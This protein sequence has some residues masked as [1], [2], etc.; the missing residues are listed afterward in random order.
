MSKIKFVPT[1]SKKHFMNIYLE[2]IV[3]NDNV[4]YRYT[5]EKKTNESPIFK[6]T[7][8]NLYFI[9]FSRGIQ[10]VHLLN[11]FTKI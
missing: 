9:I 3:N 10:N 2:I 5:G 11:Q 8:D 1:L 4:I 7:N 6:D